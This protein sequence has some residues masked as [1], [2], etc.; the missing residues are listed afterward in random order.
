MRS[1]V[2]AI[3]DRITELRE[4]LDISRAAMAEKLSI[5][6]ADYEKCETGETDI[7]I[8]MLYGI[9]EIL[10]VDATVLLTGDSPRMSGYSVTRAG[11]GVLVQRYPG[12]SY[13]SL[14]FNFLRRN[15][16][17]LLVTLEEGK[18]PDLV[19]H[20]GQEFNYALKGEMKITVGPKSFIL[21]EGDSIYFDSALPHGQSA[22]G[23]EAVFLTVIKE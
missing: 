6:E 13:R 3:P 8:S 11:E 15:M 2:A 10:G 19:T 1:D 20:S 9:A 12:Y 4:I 22:V 23:G 18:A 14:S 5:T 7:P 17:P 21:K 16:E